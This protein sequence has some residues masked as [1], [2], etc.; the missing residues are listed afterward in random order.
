MAFTGIIEI[1]KPIEATPVLLLVWAPEIPATWVPWSRLVF[2]G[3]GL[4]S[5]SAT[6]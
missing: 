2:G 4:L 3:L 5:L 1:P 6:S